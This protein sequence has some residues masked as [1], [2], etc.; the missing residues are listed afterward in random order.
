MDLFMWQPAPTPAFDFN[1]QAIFDR[2]AQDNTAWEQFEKDGTI[3][4]NGFFDYLMAEDVFLLVSEEFDMYK[5]HLRDDLGG[6]ARRGWMRHMFYS[7]T[8]QIARQDPAW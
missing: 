4:I 8:Q 2:Y 5:Y 6:E 7:V 3:N 1:A